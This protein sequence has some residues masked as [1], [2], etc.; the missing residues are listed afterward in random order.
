MSHADTADSVAPL[1]S[2]TPAADGSAPSTPRNDEKKREDHEV[3]EADSFRRGVLKWGYFFLFNAIAAVVAVAFFIGVFY[4]DGLDPYLRGSYEW[5]LNHPGVTSFLAFSPLACSMR[6][7]WGY[8][9]RGR[10]R[11]AAQQ[12][13]EEAARARKA[14]AEAS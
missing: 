12:A 9:Q 6:V 4:A 14:A 5:L 11:K 8:V 7:G 2:S 13:R 3:H 1:P 10:K